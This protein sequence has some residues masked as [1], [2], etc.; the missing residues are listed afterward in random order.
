MNAR[1]AFPA[2][3]ES[4]DPTPEQLARGCM[5][6]AVQ[7]SDAHDDIGQPWIAWRPMADI[8]LE[9]GW[10]TPAQREAAETM[11]RLGLQAGRRDLVTHRSPDGLRRGR[12]DGADRAARELRDVER[13]IGP[14]Y[15]KAVDMVVFRNLRAAPSQVAAGLDR[16]ARWL[17]LAG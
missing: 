16:A 6:S 1:H 8:Y 12:G 7:V 10:I 2:E 3:P 15:L 14:R 11:L 13:A 17:G 9:Q 4:L 5:R